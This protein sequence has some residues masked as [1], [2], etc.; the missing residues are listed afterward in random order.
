MCFEIFFAECKK[1]SAKKLFAECKKK[2][3]GKKKLS[4]HLANHLA[5]DKEPDSGSV[6]V[7]SAPPTSS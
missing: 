6:H 3:L 5:L 4:G 7:S 2:T 1:K